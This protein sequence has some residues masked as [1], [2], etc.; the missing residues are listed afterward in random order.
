MLRRPPRST[1]FPYT[2]LFRSDLVAAL[3]AVGESRFDLPQR[4]RR[5]QHDA[6]LRRR[7]GDLG[8]GEERRGRKRRGRID[9]R[10]AAVGQEEG[11]AG[12]AVLGDAVG[13]G[14]REKRADR[15]LLPCPRR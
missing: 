10:A 1:L 2:T 14:E 15:W 8:D 7:A 12:A 11:A 3:D 4:Q 13:I 6:A 5:R 9:I